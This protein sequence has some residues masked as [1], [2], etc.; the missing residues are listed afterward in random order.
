LLSWNFGNGFFASAG[1]TFMGPDG[2]GY[3]GTLTPDYWT[4]EPRL[5]VAYLDHDWH[6]TANF[7]YDVNGASAGH[8]ATYQIAANRPFPSGLGGT[9]LAAV[10]ESIGNGYSSGQQAFLDVALTHTFGNWE[11]GPVAFLKWQ[12]TNDTPGGNFTCAQLVASGLAAAG[13][14]CGKATNSAVGALVGYN[15]GPVNWQV[16]A[17]D[18]VYTQDDFGGWGI[19]IRLT[20]K[21]WG[22]DA[23]KPMLTKAPPAN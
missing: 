3:N 21:L 9:P 19:F 4:R 17:T 22:P 12:T 16:W 15:F 8:T 6:F 2:S 5:A 18:S 10:I 14:G 20:F 23:P 7:K 13:L 11:V 1:F